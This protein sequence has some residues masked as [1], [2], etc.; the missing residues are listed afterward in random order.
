MYILNLAVSDTIILTLNFFFIYLNRIHDFWPQEGIMCGFVP[1]CSE[2]SVGLTTYPIAVYSIQRYRVTVNPLQVLVSSQQTWRCTVATICGVWIVAAIFALPPERAE[3]LFCN[4]TL[5][6]FTNYYKL[7]TIFHLIVSC[8][9]PL[10]VIVFCDAMTI[11]HLSESSRPISEGH[12][13][14]D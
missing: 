11:R 10:I 1:F 13:I 2:I 14:L 4:S 7:L 5:L 6:M 9:L 12:K 8:V 3:Y